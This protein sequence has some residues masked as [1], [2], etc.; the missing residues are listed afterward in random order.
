MVVSFSGFQS[1]RTPVPIKWITA[2]PGAIVISLTTHV[3]SYQHEP[4]SQKHPT[5]NNK[6]KD[7]PVIV[8]IPSTEASMFGTL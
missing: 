4:Y 2:V 1:S 7:R 8:P 3:L 6:L 5:A